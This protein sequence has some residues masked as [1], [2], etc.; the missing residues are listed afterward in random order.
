MLKTVILDLARLRLNPVA[1]TQVREKGQLSRPHL[2]NPSWFLRK[3]RKMRDNLVTSE[4]KSFVQE[5]IHDKFGPPALIKGVASYDQTKREQ[6]VKTDELPTDQ[7]W[8]TKERR[9]GL[10]ARK[11][12]Q[13]PL[14]LKNGEKIR[15]T[16]LQIVDNHVIKYTPPEQYKPTQL[17][18]VARLNSYGCL[19]VGAESCDPSTLT[20]EYCGLFKDSGLLPKRH[21]VR[22]LVTPNAAIP[23]GTPLNVGHYRV[24]DYIDVRGKTVDHGFQGVVKRHGFKGMPASHGVTKTHR[25]PGNIGGGGEKG[26]VW[27]GTKMPG[28]MGNRWRIAKGLRIWRINTKYN[29]MWVNGSAIPGSTNG[30]VYIYDTILPVRKHKTAP[31]FPTM[32]EQATEGPDDIWFENVHNFKNESITFQPEE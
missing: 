5:I 28:H 16:L 27:P 9:T 15:T 23:V 3:E 7:V 17:P 19:L 21:L 25:R 31:P 14:W 30:L 18:N 1:V 12:G 10:I 20:K 8:T 22:F 26:R 32:F 11:I 29:V 4:N 2:R 13:Y 6:L 24:G